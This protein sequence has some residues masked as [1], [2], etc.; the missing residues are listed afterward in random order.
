MHSLVLRV[1][2]AHARRLFYDLTLEPRADEAT[3]HSMTR[4][5]SLPRTVEGD[6]ESSFPMLFYGIVGDDQH[7][8]D[9]PSFW[10][11]HEAAKVRTGGVWG[12]E[13]ITF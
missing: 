5:E 12:G 7:E 6:A 1:T 9:S 2:R 8:V 13:R 3:A 11:P 4:W 10:N